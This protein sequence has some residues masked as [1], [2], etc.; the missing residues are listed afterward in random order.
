MNFVHGHLRMSVTHELSYGDY[1]CTFDAGG[2][3]L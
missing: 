3:T 2:Y 1:G